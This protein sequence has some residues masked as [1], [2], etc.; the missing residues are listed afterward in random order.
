MRPMSALLG[1]DAKF[2]GTHP[3]LLAPQPP[4]QQLQ[5]HLDFRHSA[6]FP[7]WLPVPFSRLLEGPDSPAS[8]PSS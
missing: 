1:A 8:Y 4:V 5:Q 7:A 6:A 2:S 3:H